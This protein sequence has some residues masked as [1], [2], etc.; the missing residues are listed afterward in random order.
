LANKAKASSVDGHTVLGE[1]TIHVPAVSIVAQI[2]IPDVSLSVVAHVPSVADILE[3]RNLWRVV[4]YCSLMEFYAKIRLRAFFELRGI[5]GEKWLDNLDKLSLNRVRE[6]LRDLGLVDKRTN[7]RMLRI[8][9]V[10]NRIIHN[11]LVS[12]MFSLSEEADEVECKAQQCIRTLTMTKLP[13]SKIR[14]S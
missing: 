3:D 11:I 12:A 2:P 6:M 14:S 4:V 8:Q 9:E 7:K 10:R 13:R 1:V 5:E